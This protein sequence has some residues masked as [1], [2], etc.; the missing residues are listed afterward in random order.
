RQIGVA[1][2]FGRVMEHFDILKQAVAEQNGSIVKTIGDAIMAVFRTPTEAMRAMF[3][4]QLALDNTFQ[5][6][7]SLKTG[8]HFGPAI[9]VTLNERLDYFGTTVNFASRLERFSE[10]KDIILSETV[11]NDPEIQEFLKTN[12]D[13]FMSEPVTALLK[14]FDEE[15]C[16]WRVKRG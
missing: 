5:G 4:A 6:L 10:G 1:P 3:S 14:G 11:Y 13:L 8:I 7:L 2:A 16:L 9:A 12:G 15:I